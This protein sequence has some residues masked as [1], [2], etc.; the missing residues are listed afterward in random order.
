M[1]IAIDL[2]KTLIEYDEVK[3]KLFLLDGVSE[4]LPKLYELG[5]KFHIVTGRPHHNFDEVFKIVS[6]ISKEI[7][8]NFESIITTDGK[9]KGIYAKQKKCKYL[10]DDNSYYFGDCEENDV[11]P[12]L[13]NNQNS[14]NTVNNDW[15][16]IYNF[17]ITKYNEQ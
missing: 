15:I 11:I 16:K 9:R 8:I 3:H 7:N 17:F 4:C 2:D 1:N 5:F 13:L 10:I 6:G 14:L 12:I